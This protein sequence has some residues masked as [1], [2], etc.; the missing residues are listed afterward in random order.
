ME[1]AGITP[2]SSQQQRDPNEESINHMV[3]KALANARHP[4]SQA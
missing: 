1:S 4:I 2:S 3:E